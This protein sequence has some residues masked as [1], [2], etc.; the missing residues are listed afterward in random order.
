MT[1]VSALGFISL[2]LIPALG[3]EATR[4]RSGR[5][6]RAIALLAATSAALL[7][8]WLTGR[9]V[10]A[11]ASLRLVAEIPLAGPHALHFALD[12]LN[13][14]LL[15][16]LTLLTLAIVAGAPTLLLSRRKLRA[17][18]WLEA[19]SLLTLTTADLAVLVL[20]F[21]LVLVPIYHLATGAQDDANARLLARVFKVYHLTGLVSLVA[22]VGV[23]VYHTRPISFLDMSVLELD[24]RAVPESLRPL[25]FWLFAVA[26]LVRMGVTPLHSWLPASLERGSLLS[27]AL[28]VSLRTGFYLLARVNVPA[29]PDAAHAA[30]PTLTGLALVSAVY[31]A[32]A[33]L[34]QSDLRRMVGFL[35]VSQSGIM[36]T[37]FAFG[38][39][40]AV[41]G[42][43]L[44]WLGFTTA[45]TGLVLMIAALTAR[46]GVADMR[47][48]GGLVAKAPHLSAYFFLFGLATIAV[49]GTVAF[50]AED[51]L[52]HGALNEHPLLTLIMV[53]AMVLNAVT[54]VRAFVV[55]FLGSAS[56]PQRDTL[57]DL[58]PRERLTSLAML[59]ALLLGGLFPQVLIQAQ[60]K[61]A[62][63]IAFMQRTHHGT[64]QGGRELSHGA[65]PTQ[66]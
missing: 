29:F 60:A 20:S 6:S 42:T 51:M 2:L 33:A 28:L 7:S 41:S 52:V 53:V 21:G 22:A 8:C 62:E 61:A 64:V 30:M 16:L 4:S 38:D 65:I 50:A 26:A 37:G 27:V 54:V 63:Q 66:R 48:L 14:P 31:G 32:L 43:L 11:A 35:I 58:L 17:L 1:T 13:A 25:L 45:T 46:T 10:A 40:Q 23:L 9:F 47:K 36:L 12:S 55:T 3:A 39:A 44:Y 49:P 19:L 24:T 15:P 59:V 18:F 34:G 57:R 5:E 56:D